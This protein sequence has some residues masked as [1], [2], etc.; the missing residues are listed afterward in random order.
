MTIWNDKVLLKCLKNTNHKGE[1]LGRNL[2]FV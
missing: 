2:Y 1:V